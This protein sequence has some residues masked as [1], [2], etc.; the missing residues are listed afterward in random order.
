M[1]T[2][3]F[4]GRKQELAHLEAWYRDKKSTLLPIYGRRR[5]GKT[6]L[7]AEFLRDKPQVLYF[8]VFSSRGTNS[9]QRSNEPRRR[10]STTRCSPACR[11]RTGATC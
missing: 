4:V 8:S 3:S 1:L 10:R 7:I 2:D 6:A 5:V 11:E 9:L